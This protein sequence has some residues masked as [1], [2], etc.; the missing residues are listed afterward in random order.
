MNLFGYLQDPNTWYGPGQ[1]LELLL[2]HL[3]YTAA[4]VGIAALIG[5][6]LGLLLG[7]TG[8]LSW[9]VAALRNGTRALPALGLLV[10]VALALG[11]GFGAILVVL[12]IVAFLV[13][14]AATATGALN[15]DREAVH[16]ARALGL[17]EFQIATQVEWPLALPMVIAGLRNATVQVVAMVTVAAFVGGGGLGRLLVD[18]RDSGDDAQMF[19]GVFLIAIVAVVAY[20]LLSLLVWRVSRHARPGRTTVPSYAAAA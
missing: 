13:I 2:Q 6:P 10:L 1:T 4:A 14:L 5:I 18:G 16:A 11:S 12:T 3:G 19:A 20:L 9:L 8:R 15:A 7:H 17:S